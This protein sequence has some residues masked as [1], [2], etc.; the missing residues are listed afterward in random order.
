MGLPGLGLSRRGNTHFQERRACG[1]P[2]WREKEAGR[3]AFKKWVMHHRKQEN[4]GSPFSLKGL[5]GCGW[6]KDLPD[7]RK[8]H[9]SIRAGLVII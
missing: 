3:V 5:F 8:S 4:T 2:G 7:R 9:P 6:D 1:L